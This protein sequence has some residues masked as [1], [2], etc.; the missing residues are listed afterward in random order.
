MQDQISITGHILN[1][2]DEPLGIL[3][4]STFFGNSSGGDAFVWGPKGIWSLGGAAEEDLLEAI[5][6]TG[7]LLAGGPA[8]QIETQKLLLNPECSR[9]VSFYCCSAESC[10]DVN[11]AVEKISQ[12]RVMIVGCGGIGSNAAVILAGAG[13]RKFIL[14]DGDSIEESN[15]NRQLFWDKKDI[16]KSKTSALIEKLR[17]RFDGCEFEEVS[18]KVDLAWIKA[19]ARNAGYMVLTADEPETLIEAGAKIASE[20]EIDV[21]GAGYMH[22]IAHFLHNP[23]GAADDS[24]IVE[25]VPQVQWRRSPNSIMPSYG[26]TN[27]LLAALIASH[28]IQALIGKASIARSKEQTWD[29]ANLLLDSTSS[30][31]ANEKAN[32]DLLRTI[33]VDSLIKLKAISQINASGLHEKIIEEKERLSR[34]LHWPRFINCLEDTVKFCARSEKSFGRSDAVYICEFDGDIAG[35]ISLNSIDAANGVGEIGYWLRGVCEKKGIVSK[36]ISALIEAYARKTG[37]RR[38]VIKCASRNH[39]SS[40]V[41]ERLNFRFEGILAQAE[42]IGDDYLDQRI[43]ARI[44]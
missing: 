37:M 21:F 36:S 29:A 11:A 13:V 3:L 35:V 20:H 32:G 10:E 22:H 12:A 33:H 40:A 28:L 31:L 25:N 19:N 43:Y 27:V 16:G 38:F 44:V 17:D 18:K 4:P 14:V 24:E 26:P 30:L 23:A 15:L 41:A 39:Q 6:K 34:S 9:N 8:A 42:K 1:Y 5:Q 2:R 7:S